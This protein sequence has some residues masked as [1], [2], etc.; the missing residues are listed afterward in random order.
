MRE[1]PVL[2][3][4]LPGHL[5]LAGAFLLLTQ[6]ACTTARPNAG[7]DVATVTI[8]VTAS[9]DSQPLLGV[10][11]FILSKDGRTLSEGRTDT[12]GIVLFRKP[13]QSEQPAYLLAEH[14]DFF[15]GG[16]RWRQERD[17]YYL[18]LCLGAVR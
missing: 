12:T 3:R 9:E 13:A 18:V 5:I 7:V 17:E 1:A 16:T 8:T 14:Q 10:H 6:A 2:A 15:L 4:V 11:V